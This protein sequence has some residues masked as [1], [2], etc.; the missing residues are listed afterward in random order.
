MLADISIRNLGVIASADVEL[1]P[2]LT[3][4]T[5]ET[6]AGKTMVVTG[7]RLLAGGRADAS[8]VRGGASKAIVDGTFDTANLHSEAKTAVEELVTEIDGSVDN[9]DEVIVSR[10]VS[11]SGRSHAHLAGRKVPAAK[12][13]SFAEL[14]LTVHGQ[15][16]QLRLL[17]TTQQ[18]EA[19]DRS[20]PAI[21]EIAEGYSAAFSEWKKL[22]KDLKRRTQSSRELAQEIDRLQFGI[23]EINDVDPQSGEDKELVTRIKRLQDLD[24]LRSAATEALVAIDGSETSSA[25]S[26]FA[27]LSASSLLGNAEQALVASEDTQL[28]GLGQQMA[29]LTTR[30]RDIA[31]ELG[32]FLSSL[33]ADPTL[34][35]ESLHRQQSLRTLTRKYAGDIDGVIA[36]RDNAEE[37]LRDM[38][39]STEAIEALEKEVKKA[40]TAVMAWGKKLHDAR[41]HAADKLA[42]AVTAELRGLA[43]PK[44]SFVVEVTMGTYSASGADEVEFKLAPN[45]TATPQPLANAASGG[46]LSRI[47]LALEVVLAENTSGVTMVFDEVDAGVGGRAAVEIGR[48]LAKLATH[49]QVIVVTHLPQVAAYADHHVTVAK[50]VTD[51]SV[52]SGVVVLSP[53]ERVEELARMLAGLDDTDTGRAHAKELFHKAQ[54][55]VEGFRVP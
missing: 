7:L 32:Q 55:E 15:N 10:S 18:R 1:G 5:G 20:D 35:E 23:A 41:A 51:E 40:Q 43:M 9:E 16:D 34:L 13:Q 44:A 48:R 53:E 8:R 2:G 3:V 27:E 37:A 21:Y 25:D 54:A 39:V 31:A 19:L 11:A 52:T 4:L 24:G 46:E 26:G 36:W 42:D 22:A 33:P 50:D 12:L 49:N 28:A 14:V 47:M 30:L 6:G 29:E 38:D 17:G 45:P